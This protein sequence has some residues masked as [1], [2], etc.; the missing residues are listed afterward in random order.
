MKFIAHRGNWCGKNE[1]YENLPN[2]IDVAIS[3]DYD[4]EIDLWRKDGTLFL[5]H[6]SPITPISECYVTTITG[7][8]WIHAKNI[9]VV[10]WLQKTNTNWFWH[11]NDD[12]TITSKNIIWTYPEIL[13]PNSVINQP[14]K[15]S[16][17]WN[18]QMWKQNS[19]IGICHDDL[20]FCEQRIK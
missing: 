15:Q 7:N 19:Y 16:V 3:H 12:I 14:N 6:D 4:V 13:L 17:F 9:N 18:N 2:Y 20:L 1:E 11:Q 10:E 8:V 5:G